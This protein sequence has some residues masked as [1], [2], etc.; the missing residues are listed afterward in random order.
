VGRSSSRRS[1][2]PRERPRL[3]RFAERLTVGRAVAAIAG[4]TILL[5]VA[6]AVAARA[7]EPETFRTIG[8]GGWW[9][10]QTVSTVGYGDT[11]PESAAG[12]MLGS[13]LMLVGV[14]FVPALTSIV[15]AVLIARVQA[16]R[17]GQS[18]DRQGEIV[19]RLDRLERALADRTDRH[20]G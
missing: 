12:R 20:A 8:D 14:A 18:S 6:A 19:E 10:L 16:E 5:T 2:I 9:A 13:A 11:V 17:S 4:V 3:T 15:V 1:V 7:V